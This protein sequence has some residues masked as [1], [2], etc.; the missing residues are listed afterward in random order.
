MY[1]PLTAGALLL[2]ASLGIGSAFAQDAK[3]DWAEPR[4]GADDELGAANLMTPERVKAAA[5][6]VTEGVIHSFEVVHIQNQ[7]PIG[8][9]LLHALDPGVKCRSVRQAG[10]R[11]DSGPPLALQ[12]PV[13]LFQR[14]GAQMDA[15]A[16]QFLLALARHS[17]FFEIYGKSPEDCTSRIEYWHRPAGLVA[18]GHEMA[19]EGG[20][21]RIILDIGD[22]HLFAQIGGAAAGPDI[23]TDHSTLDQFGKFFWQAR[24]GERIEQTA[25][26]DTKY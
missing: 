22:D 19:L 9:G 2:Y 7:N 3:P 14:D 6:L 8:D 13:M 23:G 5:G 20:P 16:N 25:T 26:L 10:Q 18:Q 4:W 11:I 15:G 1:K 24:G 12:N 17:V 21:A